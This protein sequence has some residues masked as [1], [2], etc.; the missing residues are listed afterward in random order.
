MVQ[1]KQETAFLYFTPY[2]TP[3]EAPLKKEWRKES[4]EL[5]LFMFLLT[6]EY[7]FILVGIQTLSL[8]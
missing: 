2:S 1:Y 3:T 4:L 5:V 7:P 6:A 8:L